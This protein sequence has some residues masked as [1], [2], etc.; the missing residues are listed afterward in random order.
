M[1]DEV[2]EESWEELEYSTEYQI[3][4]RDG[5]PTLVHRCTLTWREEMCPPIPH[6]TKY[7]HVEWGTILPTEVWNEQA[8]ENLAAKAKEQAAHP[9]NKGWSA[10]TKHDGRK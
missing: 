4:H 1:I 10:S 9:K 8:A 5:R 7:S 6:L 2:Y 3:S